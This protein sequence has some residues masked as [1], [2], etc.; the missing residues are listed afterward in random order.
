MIVRDELVKLRE[1]NIDDIGDLL[2][3]IGPLEE[4]GVLVRRSREHLEMDV[5]HFTL[6]EHDGKVFGC[7]ALYPF[8]DE[9]MGELACLVVAPERRASGF[10]DK[11]LEHVEKR[12]RAS[13]INTLFVLTTRTA[14]W[15]VER[16]FEEKPPAILP[17]RK[18]ELY[19]GQ[20]RSKVLVKPL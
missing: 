5:D 1:A 7:V 13:G 20:R 16:G 4:Q 10:G 11:L 6:L 17:L 3:L 18:R 14:H 2:A 15:F 19:N 12:C 9:R 8:P